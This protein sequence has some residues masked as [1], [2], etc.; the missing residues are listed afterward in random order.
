[1]ILKAENPNPY[2]C[3]ALVHDTFGVDFHQCCNKRKDGSD[4]CGT[5]SPEAATRREAK[6][7]E[8]YQ[9]WMDKALAPSRRIE[10]LEA[11]K[12]DLLEALEKLVDIAG[13]SHY[14][15]QA[16]HCSYCKARAAIE[17]AKEGK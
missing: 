4:L 7:A 2:Y 14:K 10:R 6:S 11:V 9:A 13:C 8:G 12:R 1:M 15:N 17:R 16:P 3:T 5:H